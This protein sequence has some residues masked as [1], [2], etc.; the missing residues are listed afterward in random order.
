MAE[1]KLTPCPSDSKGCVFE[2]LAPWPEEWCQGHDWG[3]NIEA[4]ASGC[5]SGILSQEESRVKT[6][7]ILIQLNNF[8]SPSARS[9]EE[10]WTDESPRG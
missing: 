3:D 7:G 1:I 2:K 5:K 6:T 9:A 4:V 8:P 10:A